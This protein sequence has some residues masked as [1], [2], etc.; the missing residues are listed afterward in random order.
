VESASFE[1]LFLLRPVELVEPDANQLVQV[2]TNEDRLRVLRDLFGDASNITSMQPMVI[3]EGAKEDQTKKVVADRKLYRA[4]HPGF[5]HVTILPGGG[6]FECKTV[7]RLMNEALREYS[8]KLAAIALLDRDQNNMGTDPD[9]YELPVSMIENFLLDPEAIWHAI[10]S[11]VEQTPFRSVEDVSGAIDAILDSM[12]DEEAERR[13][14]AT[15]GTSRFRPER[16]IGKVPSQIDQYIKDLT[17]Q[18]SVAAVSAASGSG[19]KA[20]AEL[21][22]NKT[23]REHFHGKTVIQN[24]YK[25]NLHQS[26]LAKV[27]F[28]FE[29]ARHARRRR[30]VTKFFDD[31]FAQVST[32]SAALSKK[33]RA[34]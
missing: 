6:K 25:S 23:R 24:F 12:E 14:A 9:V 32:D 16:P 22:S 27:I 26:P 1:E 8:P 20:V 17:A 2:A 18:Y 10:Q 7:T 34:T 4:L 3:V 28:T 13:A 33:N 5:D 19:I 21:R 29:V 31:F 11:V 30:S 15:L